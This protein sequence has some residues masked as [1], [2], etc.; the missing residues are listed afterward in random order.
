M[1][2]NFV[3]IA[4]TNIRHRKLRSFLTIIAIVIGIAAVVSL[5]S[6]SQGMQKAIEKQ[7][8]ILGTDK[9]IVMPGGG[10]LMNAMGMFS[11][12]GLTERDIDLIERVRGVDNAVGMLFKTA[13][14][15]FDDETKHTF[16]VGVPTEASAR[17]I[18]ENLELDGRYLK[19]SDRYKAVVGYFFPK[20]L[21]F[22]KA[23]KVGN[24][25]NIESQQFEAVGSVQEIGNRQDDSQIY[26]PIDVAREMLG[27]PNEI[28]MVYAKVQKGYDASDVAEEVKEEMRRDRNL[29]IG[30]EDF[31]VQTAAQLMRTI[32]TVLGLIQMILVGIA[33]ISLLVGGVGIMNTMYTAVLE[34]TREIGILKAIGA[35]NSNIMAIFL[36]ESGIIG[37]IG[38]LGGTLLGIALAKAVE[39]VSAPMGFSM[40]KVSI[41]PE[42]VVM[43]LSFAFAIGC[44]SGTLP[45]M[46]ASRLPP[47]EALRYE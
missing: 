15:S 10:G 46:R 22:K 2:R 1:L 14:V 20:G 13:R 19:E 11:A 5:I 47:A 16:I 8:E 41:S 24:R 27:T 32:G 7:F 40:L 4:F 28:S 9:I 36:L 26:I 29:E 45:A 25:F 18:L 38:G 37:F 21:F 44:L 30:E 33:G 6:V 31:T 23:I 34:R 43:S 17:W 12:K 3:S 35:R 42:L 39:I